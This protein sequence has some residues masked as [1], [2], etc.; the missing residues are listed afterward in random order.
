[1]QSDT[2]NVS[3][4]DT[5]SLL[6]LAKLQ[7]ERGTGRTHAADYT[8]ETSMRHVLSGWVSG[9]LARTRAVPY[10]EVKLGS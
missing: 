4:D 8:L 7:P 6:R 2:Q 5:E 1:M 3:I 9:K 10:L